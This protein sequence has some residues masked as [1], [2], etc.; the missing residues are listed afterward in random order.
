MSRQ[1]VNT[2]YPLIPNS[3]EYM[4]EKRYVSVHSEDRDVTKYLNSSQFEIEL[5]QDYL[6]VST[7]KLSSYTF[8][9]NYNTFS[10]SQNNIAMT[11]KINE[12]YNPADY[13]FYDPL[14]SKMFEAFNVYMDNNFIITISE[15][16]YS[17]YQIATELTNRFNHIVSVYLY[18]YLKK[19]D[20]T[21]ELV[22]TFMNNG[23]YN[24]FVIV[25]NEVTQTLWFGNKSSGFTITN[26][27]PLYN[28]NRELK[29]LQCVQQQYLDF[30]NW[31][32][33]AY[34]GF[35]RCAV[36]TI[37][38]TNGNSPRFFYGD[39]QSGDNGNWLLPDD[40]YSN[41]ETGAQCNVF[42]LEAPAKINLMGNSYFYMEIS[43][44]NNMDEMVPFS[45]NSFTTHTNETSGINNSAF[46]K[47]PITTTPVAQWFD[48]Y[49]ESMKIFNPPAERIRRLKIKIRY[50]NGLLVDFGKFNYSFMLEFTIL[51][52][53]NIR[54]YVTY[55]PESASTSSSSVV[56]H[57]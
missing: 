45:M 12:P 21:G 56:L 50:H 55:N 16:F 44:L 51:R 29:S 7:V 42:Y 38:N 18:E 35:T 39:V 40:A 33:P 3:N 43:G 23:G 22:T 9:A 17:P 54:N 19:N 52:P 41:P 1:N 13:G 32:L 49:H 20:A 27:S 8:P 6:N 24:Q 46:A 34:L 37:S 31:G 57:K 11:F 4:I 14:L 15:G 36:S 48:T 10:L 5:P 30:S 25:Y 26:D 28:L 53:Q 47:I 2:N